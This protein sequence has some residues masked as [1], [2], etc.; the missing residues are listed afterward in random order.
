MKRTLTIL[1]LAGL[2]YSVSAQTPKAQRERQRPTFGIQAGVNAT[3]TVGT[4]YDGTKL[5]HDFIRGYHIGFNVEI[6]LSPSIYL[7]PGLRYITKGTKNTET[8]SLNTQGTSTLNIRYAELPLYFIFKAPVG[9]GRLLFG[10]G[11]TI[12]VGTGGKWKYDEAGT[13]NDGSGKVKFKNSYNTN[14][15]NPE[16]YFYIRT[17]DAS[18][19]ALVGY[20]FRNGIVFHA[21]GNYGLLNTAPELQASGGDQEDIKHL[22]IGFTVGYRFKSKK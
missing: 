2:T 6:P 3:K 10:I 21:N 16:E 14:D 8:T 18:V 11:G 7:Q 1:L 17:L 20:Q 15:P 9:K 19:G 4:G 13:Q 12:A 22:A 5:K